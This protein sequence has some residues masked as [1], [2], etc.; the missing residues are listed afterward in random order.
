M[1]DVMLGNEV[2]DR[3]VTAPHWPDLRS[4]REEGA[5]MDELLRRE[6]MSSG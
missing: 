1:P 3:G 4:R 2:T 5:W 6:V